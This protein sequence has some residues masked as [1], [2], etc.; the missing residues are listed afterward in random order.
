[1]VDAI[2][3]TEI[4]A[5]NAHPAGWF[6]PGSP[7]WTVYGAERSTTSAGPAFLVTDW[8]PFSIEALEL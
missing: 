8:M 2:D 7:G 3:C 5:R 4:A 1:M 6:Q